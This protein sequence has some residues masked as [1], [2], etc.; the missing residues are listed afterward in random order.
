MLDPNSRST[1]IE[2]LQPPPGYIFDTGLATTYSLDLTTLL[3]VP[4]HLTLLSDTGGQELIKDSVALLE[5]LQRTT[6]RIAVFCQQGQIKV[7][8]IQHILYGLLEPMVVEVISRSGGVFHP[9]LWL[10]RFCPTDEDQPV[11]Y[12]LL[13]LSRNL[14]NDR[15]WD[16]SLV[17]DGRLQRRKYKV[18]KPLEEFL[19]VLPNLALNKPS[20]FV[21]RIIVQFMK[22]IIGIK[23]DLPEGYEELSFHVLGLRKHKW[24]PPESNKLVVISPFCS[25]EALNKLAD[26]THEPQALISRTEVLDTIQEETLKRFTHC[27]T[28]HEAAETEDGE[29]VAHEKEENT[30]SGREQLQGLHAKAYIAKD[31]WYTRMIMGSANATDPALLYGSNVEILVEL[32]GRT[33]TVGGIDTILNEGGLQDILVDYDFEHRGSEPDKPETLDTD[34]LIREVKTSLGNAHLKLVCEKAEDRWKL[35]LVP[36]RSI[37][38]KEINSIAAWPITI[39]SDQAVDVSSLAKRQPLTIATCALA[40]ITGL[41]G[42]KFKVAE[43]SEETQFVLN[44]P[45]EGVPHDRKSAIVQTVVRNHDGFLRY[46]MLLL[47][48]AEDDGGRALDLFQGFFGSGQGITKALIEELPIFERLTRSFTR[49]PAGLRTV[50]K[51]IDELMET[52][53][54]QAIVPEQFLSMWKVFEAALEKDTT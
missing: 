4:L 24:F 11:F 30:S 18:N 36:Q 21:R 49:N 45:L 48:E 16:L 34:K 15:S 13:V 43:S 5:S 51:L 33:K 54:G 52:P 53:E 35:S 25:D 14:T 32:L 29:D 47:G 8:S 17:L 31:G 19:S 10:L 38:L 44:I 28:L 12:R 2:A 23:W 39:H 27:L 3:T 26:T 6:S 7:P 9:K 50:K 40:S 37:H 1:Y 20:S 22:E 46:L 42:F 41:V